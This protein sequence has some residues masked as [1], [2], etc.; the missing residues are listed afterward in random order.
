M[1][2]SQKMQEFLTEYFVDGTRD[3]EVRPAPNGW[4]GRWFCPADGTA[5]QEDR[6]IVRCPKCHRP[7]PG[8][9]LYQLIELH[10]HTWPG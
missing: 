6:G 4:G 2:L 5:M 10:P 7:F 1:P 8:P 3:W 9:L